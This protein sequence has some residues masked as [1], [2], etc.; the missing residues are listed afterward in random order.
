MTLVVPENSENVIAYSSSL[1]G[2]IAEKAKAFFIL[3]LVFYSA[4]TYYFE[5]C[6]IISV[7][8]LQRM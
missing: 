1:Q 2:V 4:A 7:G 3:M 6:F 8:K 5:K